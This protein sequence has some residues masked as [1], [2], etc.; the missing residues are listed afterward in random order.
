MLNCVSDK[1]TR[2]EFRL[3]GRFFDQG[4]SFHP[5]EMEKWKNGRMEN[6]M[7]FIFE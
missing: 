5:V 6:G 7:D 2:T 3:R 4:R 1:E